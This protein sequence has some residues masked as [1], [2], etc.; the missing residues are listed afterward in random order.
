MKEHLPVFYK[1]RRR[2]KKYAKSGLNSFDPN[3]LEGACTTAAYLT[4]LYLKDKK[5]KPTICLA[6]NHAWV[7]LDNLVIDLT[8][9]QFGVKRAV[10]ITEKQKYFKNK[11]LSVDY[12]EI[13][14]AKS[15]KKFKEFI[16]QWPDECNPLIVLKNG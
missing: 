6:S 10:Y 14:R 12:F 9:T 15:I 4:F 2:L 3:D 16:S 13:D 11:K 5:L 8:A 7:E 1:I